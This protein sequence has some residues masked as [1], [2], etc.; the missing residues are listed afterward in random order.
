MC[1]DCFHRRSS[2]ILHMV[3]AIGF[4]EAAY[5]LLQSIVPLNADADLAIRTLSSSVSP[6]EA[7]RDVWKVWHESIVQVGSGED[8]AVSSLIVAT[9]CPFVRC[10]AFLSPRG[11][12]ALRRRR[13]KYG[14]ASLP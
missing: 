8:F 6:R 3:E 13:V 2:N 12:A 14:T 10:F 4:P 5:S 11:M 7:D 1:D 9:T